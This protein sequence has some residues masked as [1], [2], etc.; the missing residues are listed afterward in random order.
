MPVLPYYFRTRAAQAIKDAGA[1]RID[2]MAL[3]ISISL[4]KILTIILTVLN[5]HFGHC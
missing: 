3:F 2:T 4:L 5:F 1:N